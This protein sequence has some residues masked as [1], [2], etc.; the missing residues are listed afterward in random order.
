[1]MSSRTGQR[2]A[3]ETKRGH[4]FLVPGFANSEWVRSIAGAAP[5]ILYVYDCINH[6][7]LYASQEISK[8]LGFSP[9]S[10]RDLGPNLL[11]ALLHPDDLRDYPAHE[12]R[13]HLL[14]DG[15]TIENDYRV[16]NASGQWRWLHSRELVFCRTPDGRPSQ[17]LG[18]AI[19][20]TARV[21]TEQTLKR[22][23]KALQVLNEKLRREVK[24]RRGTQRV[25]AAQHSLAWR[26]LRRLSASS[27]VETP[28]K[29]VLREV[30]K[31]F[32]GQAA[33]LW[34]AENGCF[35]PRMTCTRRGVL[36]EQRK[37]SALWAR[38]GRWKKIMVASRLQPLYRAVA[39]AFEHPPG[40]VLYLPLV[41]GTRLVG[42]ITIACPRPHQL[43]AA[44]LA[45]AEALRLQAALSL[46]FSRLATS[47]KRGALSDERNRIAAHLH[48]SLAQ[49]LAGVLFQLQGGLALL[50]GPQSRATVHFEEAIRLVRTGLQETREVLSAL[51][52]DP[53]EDQSLRAALAQLTSTL[54]SQGVQAR[55][56]ARGLPSPK[57]PRVEHF[58]YMA[59]QGCLR[60]L[61]MT[62]ANSRIDL[63]L[64]ETGESV[65]LEAG[66]WNDSHQSQPEAFWRRPGFAELR[67]QATALGGSTALVKHHNRG[68]RVRFTIPARALS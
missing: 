26:A 3:R 63:V 23:T 45:V 14:A 40:A 4:A 30:L 12:A 52:A 55:F 22:R 34:E 17:I 33:I 44:E 15:E 25:A 1:M 27:S 54:R 36:R 32:R 66:P 2:N 13:Y 53:L 16:R 38:F 20:V 39:A 37:A 57:A 60:D 62:K 61:T 28:L 56:R 50:E 10:I 8:V 6:Q 19:D 48:D 64:V 47:A 35:F 59:A 18:F 24:V 7:N 65:L 29:E 5:A 68:L 58:M 67:A 31:Q 46:E 51:R 11:E 21:R 41:S 49:T 9:K 42:A 43:T